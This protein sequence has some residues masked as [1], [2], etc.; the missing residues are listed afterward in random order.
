[1]SETGK[2]K[3]IDWAAEL[4]EYFALGDYPIKAFVRSKDYSYYSFKDRLYRDPRYHGR[5][6][7]WHDRDHISI[8]E[9]NGPLFLP[10]V[11]RQ[12]RSADIMVN[13][14]TLTVNENTDEKALRKLLTAIRDL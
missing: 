11:I 6:A 12:E 14:F 10:V 7:K 1:M 2:Y 5:N 13:G 9:T 4:D 8:D 3:D